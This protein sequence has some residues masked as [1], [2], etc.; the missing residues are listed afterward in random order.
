MLKPG[1]ILPP[2]PKYD[3][4]G[5][6]PG[7]GKLHWYVFNNHKKWNLTAHAHF[8]IYE[9]GVIPLIS[10][11][12]FVLDRD[13]CRFEYLTLAIRNSCH[14]FIDTVKLLSI[15]QQEQL[16]ELAHEAGT[17]IAVRA[18]QLYEPLTRQLLQANQYPRI[19]KGE[20]A[21]TK[22][23]GDLFDHITGFFRILLK[24][25][26]TEITETAVAGGS[27]LSDATDFIDIHLDFADGMVASLSFSSL[28]TSDSSRLF[29]YRNGGLLDVNF[30]ANRLTL[31]PENRTIPFSETAV[32]E[33]L[34]RQM[35]DFL[36]SVNNLEYS[37]HSL[38]DEKEVFLLVNRIKEQL[39]VKSISI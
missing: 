16:I 15:S 13:F 22:F 12:L 39:R 24:L 31:I 23:Q 11:I 8:S 17:Q 20:H 32:H 36:L 4:I 14:L 27:F 6:L 38:E 9:S 3:L 10:D 1:I 30:R 25:N 7:K 5:K 2:R 21:S 18:D 29:I 28:N 35:D 19:V 26:R 33:T 37:I 34:I